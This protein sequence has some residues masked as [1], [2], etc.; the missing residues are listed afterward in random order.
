[1]RSGADFKRID[2]AEARRL[3]A[4][5]ESELLILDVRDQKSF[6][7]GH[8]PKAQ[9]A[10]EAIIFGLL[11]ER[12]KQRPV[13]I[14]CYHGNASQTYAQMFIDFGFTEVFSLDG[15]FEHWRQAEGAPIATPGGGT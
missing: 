4:Q 14:Y 1:M 2:V 11:T 12:L 7:S 13:L 15:G 3:T 9:S 5:R 8:I 10:S 6:A